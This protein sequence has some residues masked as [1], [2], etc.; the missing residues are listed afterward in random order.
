MTPPVVESAAWQEP[1]A[2]EAAL[3]Q[4]GVAE[5]WQAALEQL[6]VAAL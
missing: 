5:P 2:P 1:Q 3:V 6:L 4:D